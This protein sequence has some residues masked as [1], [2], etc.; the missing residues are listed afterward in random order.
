M[1]NQR[2]KPKDQLIKK[3]P[4]HNIKIRKKSKSFK[5]I[6]YKSYFAFEKDKTKNEIKIRNLNS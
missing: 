1:E 2:R 4:K 3:S 5:I 6:W